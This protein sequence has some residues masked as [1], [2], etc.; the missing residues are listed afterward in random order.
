MVG[1]LSMKKFLSPGQ[2]IMQRL[3]DVNVKI[4]NIIYF[5]NQ[6]VFFYMLIKPFRSV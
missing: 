2:V 5:D 4:F 6:L 1:Q 3:F